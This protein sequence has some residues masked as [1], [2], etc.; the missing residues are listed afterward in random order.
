MGIANNDEA[1]ELEGNEME[2][3]NTINDMAERGAP[4]QE[5]IIATHKPKLANRKRD[6]VTAVV[7]A[8]NGVD[9][10]RH[11]AKAEAKEEKKRVST[12]YA[13]ARDFILYQGGFPNENSPAKLQQAVAALAIAVKW[14][15]FLGE[16]H[17][18]NEWLDEYGLS[19]TVANPSK[20]N[21]VMA[22]L[23]QEQI[24]ILQEELKALVHG[25]NEVQHTIKG[26]QDR[27]IE[28]FYEALPEEMKY[29][30]ANKKGIK[31]AQFASLAEV[32]ALKN[33]EDEK[34]KKKAQRVTDSAMDSINNSRIL[35]N[36]FEGES[37]EG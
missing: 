14:L 2:I 33:V 36:V 24:D 26:E 30:K 34:A 11:M 5:E 35:F 6:F 22:M 23:P 20:L 21:T 25:A 16:S 18:L 32:K 8:E 12:E 37:V 4:I 15:P 3:I 1:L 28:E 17:L 27:L 31:P 19:V 9:D 10:L 13:K 7:K 29:S